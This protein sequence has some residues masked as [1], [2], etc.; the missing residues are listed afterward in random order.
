MNKTTTPTTAAKTVDYEN[1]PFYIATKGIDLLFKH[2][3]SV[4][5]VIGIFLALSLLSSYSGG[6]MPQQP[7]VTNTQ[8]GAD[9][10]VETN[11]NEL[12]N[13]FQ[14]IPPQ[15]FLLAGAG[16]LLVALVVIAIVFY[17]Q[18]VIDYTSS[19]LAKGQ[20]VTIGHA[21]AA[22]MKGF[23]GYAWVKT[24]VGLKVFLWTL[25]F[26]VP[27]IIMAVRYSLSGISYF[28]KNLHGNAAVRDSLALTKGAWLTTGA[29]Q[30][31]M[32]IVTLGMAGDL[33]APGARAILYRQLSAVTAAGESKPK[34]HGLSW[35]V[36]ILPI[37]LFALIITAIVLLVWAF[38]HYAGVTTAP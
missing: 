24:I 35:A 9:A 1:N 3:Q 31:I 12:T 28:D 38:A 4:G 16:I 14:Q 13:F 26:I 15:T 23:W 6:F 20:D 10:S 18:A 32:H 36:L 37:V 30:M 34:A 5:I 8:P 19:K 17:I 29:A 2:A 27:G 11:T 33:F 21:M 22:A 25:L 7:S